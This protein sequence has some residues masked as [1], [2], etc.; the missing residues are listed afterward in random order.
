M[1]TGGW[2][3]VYIGTYIHIHVHMISGS[4]DSLLDPFCSQIINDKDIYVLEDAKTSQDVLGFIVDPI[5]T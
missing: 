1:H 5:S 2:V 3:V 4:Q